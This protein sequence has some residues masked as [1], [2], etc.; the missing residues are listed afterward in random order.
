LGN[1]GR[2]QRVLQ[3]L[4]QNAIQAKMEDDSKAKVRIILSQAE[5]EIIFEMVDQGTGIS[6]EMQNRLFELN[7]TTRSQ[8]LGVGL[9]MSRKIVEQ[10][11]GNLRLNY[12]DERG[13]AFVW[14]MPLYDPN[15]ERSVS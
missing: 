11:G 9:A 10:H 6:P 12:S 4:F 5:E 15:S 3:N 1:A 7:F 13:T 14:A 2:L 8:G